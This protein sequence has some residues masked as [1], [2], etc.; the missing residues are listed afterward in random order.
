MGTEMGREPAT[1]RSVRMRGRIVCGVAGEARRSVPAVR[2]APGVRASRM[3]GRVLPVS[4]LDYALDEASIATHPVEPRDQ[5]R[6]LVV[7]L[8]AGPAWPRSV[9]RV[10]HR[11][12]ADLP[13]YLRPGDAMVVNRTSVVAA[14]F[15]ARRVGDGRQAE[16][17]FTDV[18]ASCPDG[19][20]W[21]ALLRH[22]ARFHPG[23]ELELL[24]PDGGA[25]RHSVTLLERTRE[26][27]RLRF[28]GDPAPE[29]VMADSGWTPLPP[30]ILKARR[31]L[32]PGERT[33]D[34]ADRRWYQTLF[35]RG[36]GHPSVA[37]PT[38]G[39]HFTPGLLETLARAGVATHQLALQVGIGTF[40][41]VE[42]A[43]LEEHPMHAEW[44]S[45]PAATVGAL[46][47]FARQHRPGGARLLAVG[48]TSVR[49]LESLPPPGEGEA[50]GWPPGWL[51]EFHRE[52]DGS[53]HG[54]SRLLI[55]P[56][57]RFRRVEHLLTN[58][59]LPRSTLMA[60]VGAFTGLPALRELYAL[61]QREGYRF[62][63]WGDAML[64]L[65]G[66]AAASADTT[67]A[68][69]RASRDQGPGAVH[70]VG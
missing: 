69:T 58:F 1:A 37:A 56:G 57:W 41:P 40:K 11:R 59:H 68:G 44:F 31:D 28:P 10:E 2:A 5:A 16:G 9:E 70:A 66:R 48:T 6:M 18:V 45:V 60:L 21:N 30:Y 51:P 7:H 32:H 25:P 15:K 52:A 39:L 47:A 43:T 46:D 55:S 33:D 12:V 27:W 35:A 3:L 65:S 4:E 62:Y 54:Q 20:T 17:L 13:E 63:S 19:R 23:E 38:A 50:A 14:R 42:A 64:I 36:D 24:P 22:A 8:G 61:A 67:S 53:L 49:V 29:A 34:R 26:G